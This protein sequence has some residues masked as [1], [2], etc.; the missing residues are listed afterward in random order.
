[1]QKRLFS[2]MWPYLV[3]TPK[4]VTTKIT[5]MWDVTLC[6]FENSYQHFGGPATSIFR[7]V[8]T[9]DDGDSSVL[10]NDRNYVPDYTA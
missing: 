5:V 10:R 6:S 9:H 7:V 8:F 3:L 1:M 2:G 4:A